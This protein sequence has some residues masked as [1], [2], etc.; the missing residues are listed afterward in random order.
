MLRLVV[1]AQTWNLAEDCIGLP[2]ANSR[3]HNRLIHNEKPTIV[4]YLLSACSVIEKLQTLMNH[5]YS[6]SI[7]VLRENP[8]PKSVT[9]CDAAI[10]SHELRPRN[11]IEAWR[12]RRKLAF[13][14]KAEMEV[15]CTLQHPS[16]YAMS[17]GACL[18]IVKRM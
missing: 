4:G 13:E 6:N 11:E 9:H 12:H 14:M 2:E 1:S 15:R 7:Y 5:P 16:D 10:Q 3:S 17:C 8:I 18:R